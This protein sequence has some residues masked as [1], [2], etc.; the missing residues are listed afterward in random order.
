MVQR[1]GTYYYTSTLGDR[2][3]LRKTRDIGRLADAPVIVVWRAPDNGPQSASVWAPELHFVDGKWYLYYT[4]A[5]KAH[6]DDAHRHLF[7][8]EN[9]SADPTQGRWLSRGMLKTDYNGIDPTVFQSHGKLYFV[10]S[11]YVGDHSDLVIAPMTNPWTLGTPQVDIARP[12]YAWEMQGGRRILEGPE[13]LEGPTGKLFLSYSAS[14]CWSDHYA[15]GLLSAAP[16]ADPLSPAS[17]K[18]SPQPVFAESTANDVY[19][20]GHN[21]FFQSPDGKQTWIVYHANGGPGWKCGP[22]RSPR[23]QQVHWRA[24]GTPYFGV[25]AKTDTPLAVPSGQTATP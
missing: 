12:T 22:R 15:L 4:A 13:F 23:I 14:A 2:I 9:A 5:D 8:L 3:A 7:V 11:A 19:A 18:K 21:G 16:N 25:P 17:W 20:P 1:D 6:D 24:D 10:Y